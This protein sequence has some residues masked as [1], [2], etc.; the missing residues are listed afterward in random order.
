M[1]KFELGAKLIEKGF[2]PQATS[3]KLFFYKKL[4]ACSLKPVALTLQNLSPCTK[5][6]NPF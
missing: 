3:D 4:V 5:D 1:K 6:F 2:K